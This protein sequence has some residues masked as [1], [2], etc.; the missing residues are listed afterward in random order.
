M[1]C[2]VFVEEPLLRFIFEQNLQRMIMMGGRLQGQTKEEAYAEY[3][4][5][6]VDNLI[7]LAEND[8]EEGSI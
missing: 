4:Q 7:E 6:H 3:L 1:I 5:Q 8:E 2:G